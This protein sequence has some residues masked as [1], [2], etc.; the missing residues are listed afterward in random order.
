M[1]YAHVHY[2][3]ENKEFFESNFPADFI[4]EGLDQ[5]RG[6]FYTLMVL[7]TAL[8]DEP[9]F[10]NVVCSGLVLAADGK[11]MSKRLK[12]YPDPTEVIDKY[13]SD[14]LR[15][16]LINSPVVKA[17]TLR[18]KE[19]GVFSVVKDVLLPWYN[20]YFM[21]TQCAT[22]LCK[23]EG[24]A[25]IELTRDHPSANALDL[26]LKTQLE[27]LVR[28]VREEMG[29][30]RV[31]N[32]VPALMRFIDRLTNVYVRLNRRRLKGKDGKEDCCAAVSSLY[33]ALL[34]LAQLMAPFTPFIAETMFQNLRRADPSMPPSVHFTS[35]PTA[36]AEPTPEALEN[37]KVVDNV[38]TI[39]EQARLLR[40]RAKVPVKTPLLSLTIASANPRLLADISGRLS[41]YVKDEMNIWELKTDADVGR[42]CVRRLE[43]NMAVLGKKLGRD[44][45]KVKAAMVNLSSADVARF[46][47]EGQI[48]V[49][50]FVLTKDD[51]KSSAEYKLPG[52]LASPR[53]DL[54][55]CTLEDGSDLVVVCDLQQTPELLRSAFAREVINRLQNL[56]K[57][58]GM[59]PGDLAS[60][61]LTGCEP[62]AAEAELQAVLAE[63]APAIERQV[64]GTVVYATAGAAASVARGFFCA[65]ER[66][67]LNGWG[68]E[69]LKGSGGNVH[70]TMTVGRY[71]PRG[72]KTEPAGLEAK[73]RVFLAARSAVKAG[74]KVS[75]TIDGQAVV[76]HV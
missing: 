11:K 26:W 70:L 52:D 44:L 3:F 18:F 72:L 2:P 13:G 51:A 64:D 55:G 68:S 27:V 36:G 19:D 24:V 32:V 66:D 40:D 60:F 73:A 4:S 76:I 9:P 1:P 42:Y 15:L 71:E 57:K 30:Y 56:R 12:N 25:W 46:E 5:T 74:S 41:S 47:T 67:D 54:Q 53:Y 48:T 50:G 37:M 69:V 39:I 28:E 7:G 45:A 65:P 75:A 20:A 43:P 38:W 16:Y 6:W 8:F 34:E 14:A 62:A 23:E 49:E 22:R 21:L 29:R 35:L 59:V 33:R 31:Y 63:V 10:R 61:V 17:E 58:A